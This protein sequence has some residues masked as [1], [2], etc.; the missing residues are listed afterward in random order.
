MVGASESSQGI[1]ACR[2]VEKHQTPQV[3]GARLG[4]G[5]RGRAADRR[6]PREGYIFCSSGVHASASPDVVFIDSKMPSPVVSLK[7]ETPAS[8]LYMMSL[9]KR[10]VLISETFR[11]EKQKTGHFYNPSD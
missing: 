1:P 3:E 2:Q 11:S 10:C 9:I 4:T 7:R 5:R 6:G 8:Y